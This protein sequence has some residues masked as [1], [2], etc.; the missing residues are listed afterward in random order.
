MDSLG[1]ST[2]PGTGQSRGAGSDGRLLGAI[3]SAG[4][5]IEGNSTPDRR[6]GKRGKMLLVSGMMGV[7]RQSLGTLR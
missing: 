2:T 6:K 5:R 7:K 1:N 3:V 4:A